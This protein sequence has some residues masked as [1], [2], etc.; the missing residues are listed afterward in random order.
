VVGHS[1]D[2][3][4]YRHSGCRR[5][6]CADTLVHREGLVGRMTPYE[7]REEV[8]DKIDW[9]GGIWEVLAYGLKSQDMPDVE[10]QEAWA[11]LEELYKAADAQ[12]DAVLAILP[13]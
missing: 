3:Y 6:Q 1:S 13:Q 8:R 12:A 5:G 4:S 2:L 11:K 9:E 7:N 10:L